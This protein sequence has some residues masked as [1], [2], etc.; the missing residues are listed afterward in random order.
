LVL[1]LGNGEL[2]LSSCTLHLGDRSEK[3]NNRGREEEEQ[4]DGRDKEEGEK[5]I[6]GGCL[7]VYGL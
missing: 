2:C 4:I 5:R 6:E 7:R 1:E 3:T